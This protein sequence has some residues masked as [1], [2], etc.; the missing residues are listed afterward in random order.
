LAY[1]LPAYLRKRRRRSRTNIEQQYQSSSAVALRMY[2]TLLHLQYSDPR[3][4]ISHLWH[5]EKSKMTLS[6]IKNHLIKT[7]P[8][9]P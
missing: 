9:F 8:K 5:G 7:S 4:E 3:K 1:G 6:K 2:S